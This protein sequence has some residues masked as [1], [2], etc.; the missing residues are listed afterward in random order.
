LGL[1]GA[2]TEEP[3]VVPRRVVADVLVEEGGG[4]GEFG[5]GVEE[6]EVGDEP[7]AVG[8]DVVVFAV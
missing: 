1:R 5:G 7:L 2:E 3:A 6:G 8:P 4:G